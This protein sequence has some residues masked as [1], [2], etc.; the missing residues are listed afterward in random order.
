MMLP[1]QNHSWQSKRWTLILLPN[2]CTPVHN[3]SVGGTIFAVITC[4][5]N[6]RDDGSGYTFVAHI[7]AGIVGVCEYQPTGNQAAGLAG[8]V[9]MLLFLILSR[10]CILNE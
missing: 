10:T 2:Y 4:G 8:M 9:L 1:T 5:R 3:R 6:F 7:A